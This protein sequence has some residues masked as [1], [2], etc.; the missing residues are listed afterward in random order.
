MHAYQTFY[1]TYKS[2][3]DIYIVYILEAHFVEKDS[4][5][6]FI[7]GW[8]IGYQYNYEQPKTFEQRLKM[9]HLLMDEYSP[10]IPVLV[11]TMENLFQNVYRPWPDRAFIFRDKTIHYISRI[12]DDGTREGPWTQ[13]IKMILDTL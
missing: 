9:V 8:P 4:S 1:D 5:G 2:V 10:S 12:N 7:G 13:E 11:D 6:N 3:A